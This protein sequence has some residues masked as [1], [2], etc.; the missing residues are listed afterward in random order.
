[1]RNILLSQR[2]V[3]HSATSPFLSKIV[4]LT[5]GLLLTLS[6]CSTV[7]STFSG[8]GDDNCPPPTPLVNFSPEKNIHTGWRTQVGAGA[9][10][11]HTRL[12]TAVRDGVIYTV[13]TSGHVTAL[14]AANGKIIWLFNA[15]GCPSSGPSVQSGYVVFGMQNGEVVALNS[16]HGSLLWR[17]KVSSQ[18]L[19]PP[20]IAGQFVL[21]KTVDGT[22]TALNIV[23]GRPCWN[24]THKSPLIM[25]QSDSAP[26]V[27][28]GV[29]FVGFGD[30]QLFA[31]QLQTG[32][33]LWEQIVAAPRGLAELDSM[34]NII[35]DPIV[36]GSIVYVA[37]YQGQ[38]VALSSQTGQVLWQRSLST[39]NNFALQGNLIV[40]ADEQG[41]IWAIN[42]FNGNLR[43]QQKA[44]L[45]RGLTAPLI[46]C[47]SIWVGDLE[48]YLHVLSARDGHFVAR[49]FVDGS[50]LFVPPVF[51]NQGVLVRSAG[52]ELVKVY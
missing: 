5:M 38:L 13:D 7:C 24:F 33:C 40:V 42:R 18:L 8:V 25:L 39:Y 15:Q 29:V 10:R 1:M 45:N 50:G 46:A 19:A 34:V 6:G 43:W 36:C 31:L 22:L 12:E 32:K 47:Q 17:A 49:H 9:D 41:M 4:F 37:A 16:C 35:A 51:D 11:S 2:H 44:L 20:R 14:N 27:S 21:V 23:T 52:G 28:G 3:E 26:V 48:G 30:G